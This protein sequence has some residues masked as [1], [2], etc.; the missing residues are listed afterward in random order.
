MRDAL[1]VCRQELGPNALVLSTTMVAAR[2]WRGLM[3]VREV[4]LTAALER[5]ESAARPSVSEN[6]HE[7]SAPSVSPVAAKLIATGLD[8]EL[9]EEIA[10][11]L[12][13]HARRGVSP[14]RVRAALAHRMS[15]LAAVERDYQPI[16]VFVGPPGAGKTTTVAK[17]AAQARARRGA[18]FSLIAADGFRVG[19]IDQLR[20][21]ADILDAPFH[22]TPSAE[23][24]EQLLTGASATPMLVD[25][26]G[27]APSD[28]DS[29]GLFG[30]LKR[31]PSVRTHL[32]LPATLQPKAA[33][34][35]IASYADAQPSRLV[36]TKLDEVDS[37]SPLMRVLRDVK[38]PVSYLC[39]GQRVPDDLAPATADLLAACVLGEST[40][41]A[42]LH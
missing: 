42:A 4:E 20:T 27:R 33:R 26:A 2:G 29:R 41:A 22:A 21:Y 36:L 24:L 37:L 39:S 40:P 38:V 11:S 1:S 15:E 19:A 30:V 10:G 32:V 28:P 14:E 16:E 7:G 23:A 35:L 13:A 34:R 17:I 5:E 9:A 25:T 12:P 31:L 8:P 3:G 6:R 18:R